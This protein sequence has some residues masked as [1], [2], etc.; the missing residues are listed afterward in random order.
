MKSKPARSQFVENDQSKT[1]FICEPVRRFDLSIISLHIQV[2]SDS[3]K[4]AGII[5]RF[6]N[7]ERDGFY[8]AI[9][10]INTEE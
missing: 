5:K 9:T 1:T 3:R 4:R 7:S 10:I 6:A 2:N 8:P